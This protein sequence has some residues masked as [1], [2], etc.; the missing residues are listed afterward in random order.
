M[1]FV[2]FGHHLMKIGNR[3]HNRIV[4]FLSEPVR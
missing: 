4:L 1:H 3:F 2:E